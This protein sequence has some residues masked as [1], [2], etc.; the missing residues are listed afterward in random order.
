MLCV[1]CGYRLFVT[2][3]ATVLRAWEI[4]VPTFVRAATHASETRLRTSTYSSI[5]A[6]L[7]SLTNVLENFEININDDLNMLRIP[8][9]I[10]VASI[11]KLSNRALRIPRCEGD[12]KIQ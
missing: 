6:P 9:G 1:L 3:L 7:S 11:G 10:G 12:D 8:F 2:V 4:A 5:S